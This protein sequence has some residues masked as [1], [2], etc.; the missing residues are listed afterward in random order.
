M[1]KSLISIQNLVKDETVSK[2]ETLDQESG[3]IE[4][5]ITA[6][7]F[8]LSEIDEKVEESKY[9]SVAEDPLGDV[10]KKLENSLYATQF[11][12]PEDLK[13]FA[14]ILSNPQKLK[15]TYLSTQWA[16][17]LKIEED[18][19]QT[20]ETKNEEEKD[21]E[22]ENTGEEQDYKVDKTQGKLTEKQLKSDIRVKIVVV[23]QDAK[24]QFKKGLRQFLSPVLSKIDMIP[25]MGM[26]HSALM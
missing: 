19:N 20:K 18:L 10:L 21:E 12:D 24:S 2:S 16:D 14:A 13:K 7:N 11:S 1:G 8:G 23:D 15:S 4:F 17:T 25:Q 6:R 22:T 5:T 3:I 26:F 9:L